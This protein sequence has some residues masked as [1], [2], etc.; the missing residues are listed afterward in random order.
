MSKSFWL[1]D[2]SNSLWF[3]AEQIKF[4]TA[5][6]TS[7][8]TFLKDIT[9]DQIICFQRTPSSGL[10]EEILRRAQISELFS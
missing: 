9:K 7:Q 3:C 4:V 2:A 5:L 10:G 6:I 8:N 1:E